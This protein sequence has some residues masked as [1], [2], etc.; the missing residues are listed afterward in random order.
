M[1][2]PSDIRDY[3]DGGT[4]RGSRNGFARV[5]TTQLP[6]TLDYVL[7]RSKR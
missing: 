1:P 6:T 3:S 5:I 7:E 4:D 2:V